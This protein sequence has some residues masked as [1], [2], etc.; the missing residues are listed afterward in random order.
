M[1]GFGIGNDVS[2]ANA[3]LDIIADPAKALQARAELNQA[4][5]EATAATVALDEKRSAIEADR[6]SV[7]ADLLT[8]ST[9]KAD[10]IKTAKDYE[11]RSAQLA[12]QAEKLKAQAAAQ[13]TVAKDQTAYEKTLA[14]RD[15]AA[16]VKEGELFARE[17]NV[18]IR[19]A[20]LVNSRRVLAE[21]VQQAGVS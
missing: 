9:A 20:A 6:A 19:E 2:S 5:D 21:A 13:A 8:L 3:L 18:E 10:L 16:T 1:A 17:K 14:A 12:A 15:A 11:T 7:D 4:R